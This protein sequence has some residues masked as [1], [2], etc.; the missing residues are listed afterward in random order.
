MKT[1]KSVINKFIHISLISLAIIGIVLVLIGLFADLIIPGGQSK[2]GLR[3]IALLFAGI[4][5]FSVAISFLAHPI[6][7]IWIR[8][9]LPREYQ[10]RPILLKT[11]TEKILFVTRLALWFGLLAGLG[12][13][14]ILIFHK[15]QGKFLHLGMDTVWMAPLAE[16]LL[17]SFCG[18]L[19]VIFFQRVTERKFQRI[20]INTFIF[21]T[22][23]SWLYLFPKLH[24]L[25]VWI[26]ALGIS[27]QLTS[28]ILKSDVFYYFASRTWL[29]SLALVGVVFLG[30]NSWRYYR[31]IHQSEQAPTPVGAPNVLFIVMDTERAQ[32]MSLYGYER[33]TTPFLQEYANKGASFQMAISPSSWTF[34]SHASMFTGQYPHDL[35]ISWTTTLGKDYPTLAEYLGSHGYRTAG[36]SANNLYASYEQGLDQGFGRFKDHKVSIGNFIISSTIARR[37]TCHDP[38]QGIGCE[39]RKLLR[40]YEIIGRKNASE[41]NRELLDW[42]SEG[43]NK[44]Y[45]A[46]L[47]Y[48]ETHGPYLPP[49]P[50]NTM[51]G[52][53]DVPRPWTIDG[54]KD[55]PWTEEEKAVLK[56]TY[57]GSVAYLDD[58]LREL[59]NELEQRGMLA[60]TL[61]IITS[62]HGEEFFEHGQW[63]HGI[64]LYMT[65]VHVPLIMVYPDHI[66]EYYQVH[67]PVA[68][69]DL[70]ITILDIV[71]LSQNAPIPGQSMR[72]L[73]DTTSDAV[74]GEPFILSEMTPRSRS[75]NNVDT[76]L[77]VVTDE[78]HYIRN[79]DGTE[80]L[81]ALSDVAELDN[82][83]SDAAYA[84]VLKGIR[85][86]IKFVF[87]PK[88]GIE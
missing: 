30:L 70:P 19:M 45:F 88:A 13:V 56:D 66:P 77:S 76:Y 12:D 5:L 10:S 61:V 50:F 26:L 40:A 49:K 20:V 47:N 67:T 4:L 53:D 87:N 85:K 81:Y 32:S 3:Q 43:E 14:A 84:S 2:F 82:L 80:E 7:L 33:L 79:P 31:E 86:G 48:F 6:R 38:R 34:P 8:I 55:T 74:M 51:F 44:P 75:I 1:N 28:M 71:G 42:L 37:V 18:I 68:L 35:S 73:W 21:L 78:Y 39:V 23:I 22:F 25:A 11:F 16:A 24:G 46:F 63:D 29:Y 62:D 52:P 9:L 69:Q 58:Q 36:F 83:A 15:S 72:G 64:N 59:F 60:N 57:D 27:I 65:S 41:V 17:F 54:T